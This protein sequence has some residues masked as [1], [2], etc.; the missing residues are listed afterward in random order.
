M[1]ETAAAILEQAEAAPVSAP[2]VSTEQGPTM[3]LCRGVS[4]LLN[5]IEMAVAAA[6]IAPVVRPIHPSHR[7]QPHAPY[8]V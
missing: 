1:D 2:A 3:T 6:L 5:W 7:L 4:S 8:P